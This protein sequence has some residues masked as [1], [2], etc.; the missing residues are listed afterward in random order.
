MHGPRNG[1]LAIG[2]D[3]VFVV[4][5]Q[6]ARTLITLTKAGATGVTALE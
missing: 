1:M 6:T 2:P 4:R 3:G 5:G